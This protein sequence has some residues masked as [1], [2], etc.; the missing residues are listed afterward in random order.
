M[1]SKEVERKFQDG[2]II[3]KE[4][5][6]GHS[7]FLV[8]SGQVEIVKKTAK[9]VVRLAIVSPGEVFGEKGV[10]DKSNRSVTARAI[11]NV[12]I[13]A[14]KQPTE[15]VSSQD[16]ANVEQD[17]NDLAQSVGRANQGLILP[18]SSTLVNVETSKI[19]I[20]PKKGLDLTNSNQ[21]SGK[22]ER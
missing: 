15:L 6:Q 21:I 1:S 14:V 18:A 7:A 5:D 4:G 20:S 17:M 8:L 11:G 2:M 19:N 22:H 10:V 9:G 12:S 3:F 13:E 16:S